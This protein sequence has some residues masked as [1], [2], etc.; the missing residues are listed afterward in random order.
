MLKFMKCYGRVYSK[1]MINY[2]INGFFIFFFEIVLF[3]ILFLY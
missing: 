1:R 3:I 2:D